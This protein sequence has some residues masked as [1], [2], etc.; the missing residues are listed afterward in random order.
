MAS[1]WELLNDA[2]TDDPKDLFDA[3]VERFP[4]IGGWIVRLIGKLRGEEGIQ[5]NSLFIE[6]PN[7]EWSLDEPFKSQ[8][9]QEIWATLHEK[10][11]QEASE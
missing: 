10:T 11:N 5:M 4:V 3:R 9:D 1:K 2:H 6:D 7:H 8:R